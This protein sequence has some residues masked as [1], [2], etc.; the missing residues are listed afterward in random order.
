MIDVDVA[1]EET[2]HAALH[3]S[4]E[5]AVRA[6]MALRGSSLGT[7][8]SDLAPT[9]LAI[10]RMAMDLRFQ[11]IE[12]ET[13]SWVFGL[14]ED[15]AKDVLADF[16]LRMEIGAVLE[17]SPASRADARLEFAPPA[18]FRPEPSGKSTTIACSSGRTIRLEGRGPDLAITD[19][20]L[21]RKLERN[22]AWPLESL[23]DLLDTIREWRSTGR[24]AEPVRFEPNPDSKTG[25]L[26]HTLARGQTRL[27]R[28]LRGAEEGFLV[29]RHAGSELRAEALRLQERHPDFVPR[30]DVAGLETRALLRWSEKGRLIRRG[31]G[32]AWLR[33]DMT[34]VCLP[35]RKP[36]VCRLSLALPDAQAAGAPD[37]R[38]FLQSLKDRRKN[39]QMAMS[40]WDE[41]FDSEGST[42]AFLDGL[43]ESR[44]LL[45]RIDAGDHDLV[46]L[47]G[48]YRKSIASVL[49]GV[50]FEVG[51]EDDGHLDIRPRHP[52]CLAFWSEE[53]GEGKIVYERYQGYF[54]RLFKILLRWLEANLGEG[55]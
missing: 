34:A 21:G 3:Q 10:R 4:L 45:L 26:F 42:W 5:Q 11:L 35:D 14:F 36:P 19:E 28:E 49:L 20:T 38:T 16:R 9:V 2:V 7:G 55:T 6:D 30:Y 54:F 44:C 37:F 12:E 31:V 24:N 18:F 46:L 13:K 1:Y 53:P 41:W 27:V 29:L 23:V 50:K 47:R 43:E 8:V 22:K 48:P 15:S 51:M 25:L 33:G 52:K 39:R 40:M 17:A 32:E